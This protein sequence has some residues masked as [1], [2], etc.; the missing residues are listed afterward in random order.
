MRAGPGKFGA[1]HSIVVQ[2]R[3]VGAQG[4]E[5]ESMNRRTGNQSAAG[6]NTSQ[7]CRRMVHTIEYVI[8]VV[9]PER[10]QHAFKLLWSSPRLPKL[11]A[12]WSAN[13]HRV[14]AKSLQP[15]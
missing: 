4:I 13:T 1:R 11:G 10:L 9:S 12:A 7:R 14:N 5:I 6:N 2:C 8:L 3:N 15:Q